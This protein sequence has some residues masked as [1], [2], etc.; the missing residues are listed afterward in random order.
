VASADDAGF[1]YPRRTIITKLTDGG[2]RVEQYRAEGLAITPPTATH[3]WLAFMTSFAV[4]ATAPSRLYAIITEDYADDLFAFFQALWVSADGGRN[5]R[6]L[7]PPLSPACAYPG[8]WID[9]SDS[10]I[11]LACGRSEFLKSTDGG[12]SWTP[13]QAPDAA[14]RIWNLQIGPG[15]PAILYTAGIDRALW[16]SADG[17]ETWQRSGDL[18]SG[19]SSWSLR[20]HATNPYVLFTTSANSFCKTENGGATWTKLAELGASFTI[21]TDSNAPDTLYGFSQRR[22]EFR[23]NDRQTFLRNLFGEKQVAPGSLVSIY[24]CDLANETRVAGS[25]PLPVN[26]ATEGRRVVGGVGGDCRMWYEGNQL[27][28]FTFE[29]K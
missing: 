14:Q 27:D 22:Q 4:D 12:E 9:P 21:L 1:G 15:S 3:S 7:D 25:V 5:W 11:Y 2:Q 6:R 10:A 23:L 28:A 13:K 26:L 24:G 18:P 8:I 29:M 19:L 16:R 20:V 17:A